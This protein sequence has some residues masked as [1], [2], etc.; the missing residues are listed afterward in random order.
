ML[1]CFLYRQW[2]LLN[3]WRWVIFWH[4]YVLSSLCKSVKLSITDTILFLVTEMPQRLCQLTLLD[5][6][7]V[8]VVRLPQEWPT[9]L[10]R[11][12]YTETWQ[13]ETYWSLMRKCARYGQWYI[14]NKIIFISDCWFWHVSSSARHWLLCLS[15]RENPCEMD[16]SRGSPL[17]E[18]LHCQWH[19]ELWSCFLWNMDNGMQA[20]LPDDKY[21]GPKWLCRLIRFGHYCIDY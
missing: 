18:V 11:G 4:I 17:Q 20:L 3:W 10:E 2:L 19:V 12:S 13:P 21:R 15:W 14:G 8:S 6:C 16:S 7:W 5:Y 1:R 9:C